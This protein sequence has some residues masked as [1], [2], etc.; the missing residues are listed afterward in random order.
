MIDG[1]FYSDD[2]TLFMTDYGISGAKINVVNKLTGSLKKPIVDLKLTSPS[3]KLF[4]DKVEKSIITYSTSKKTHLRANLFN[5]KIVLDMVETKNKYDIT[6]NFHEMNFGKILDMYS[7]KELKRRPKLDISVT[8]NSKFYL[9]KPIS[10][11]N[12]SHING[13][14]AINNIKLGNKNYVFTNR[15]PIKLVF[16]NSELKPTILTLGKDEDQLVTTISLKSKKLKLSGTGTIPTELLQMFFQNDATIY[17]GALD[18][19]W[20][21]FVDKLDEPKFSSTVNFVNNKFSIYSSSIS[22]SSVNGEIEIDGNKLNFNNLNGRMGVGSVNISGNLKLLESPLLNLDVSFRNAQFVYK[23]QIDSSLDGDINISVS[24]FLPASSSENAPLLKF[25]LAIDAKDSV[26]IKNNLANMEA[27]LSLSLLGTNKNPLFRGDIDVLKGKFYY[28]KNEFEIDSM[29]L[30]FADSILINPHYNVIAQ[31]V[32]NDVKI[33]DKSKSQSTQNYTISL[34]TSGYLQEIS[35]NPVIITSSPPLSRVDLAQLLTFGVI[36]RSE[37]EAQAVGEAA[38]FDILSSQLQDAFEQ[39]TRKFTKGLSVK[40]ESRYSDDNKSTT[41]ALT[42]KKELTDRL[43]LKGTTVLDD[44]NSGGQ[45]YKLEF[46]LTPNLSITSGIED[47]GST[48]GFTE[49][50]DFEVKIPY[51]R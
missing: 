31:T 24:K 38:V 13:F 41:P 28:Q 11:F 36:A 16:K 45:E 32:I 33:L 37:D 42:L 20:K 17:E 49:T 23:D 10:N 9:T 8:S 1:A 34:T 30:A 43:S 25:G 35:K 51:G 47:D 7:N 50:I 4:G 22:V 26:F 19:K 2:Y 21:Y 5:N 18:F 15:A 39:E 3:C 29:H 14:L 46:L 27:K 48:E 44:N 40:I 6:L 12:L